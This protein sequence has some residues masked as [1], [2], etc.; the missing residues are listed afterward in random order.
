MKPIKKRLIVKT[1]ISKVWAALTG[2]KAIEAWMGG[3]VKSN[4][5]IG[6]RYAYFG[7]ETTGRYT[8]VEKP[9]ELAYTWRQAVWPDVLV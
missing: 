4:P 2:R 6:G 9:T 5:R 3:P 7:G 8:R 1:S